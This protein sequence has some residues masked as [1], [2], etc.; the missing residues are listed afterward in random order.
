LPSFRADVE[1][2][3]SQPSTRDAAQ[4]ALEYMKCEST[5]GLQTPKPTPSLS[6]P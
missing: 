4:V 6:P 1:R 5:T 3:G 2:D